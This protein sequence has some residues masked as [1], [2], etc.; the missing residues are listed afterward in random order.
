MANLYFRRF[1]LAWEQHGYRDR[2]TAFVINYA[3]DLVICCKPGNGPAAMQAMRHLMKR[4]GLTVERD[5]DET[6]ED[7]GRNGDVS[8]IRNRFILRKR[9]STVCRYETFEEV[10]QASTEGNLRHDV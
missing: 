3:D 2:Y 4:L 1:L 8:R 6:G 9:W 7:S 10:H 5:E